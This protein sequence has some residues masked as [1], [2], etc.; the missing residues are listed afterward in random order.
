ME[1]HP[2][3]KDIGGTSAAAPFFAASTALVLQAAKEKNITLD[4]TYQTVYKLANSDAYNEVFQDVVIGN[5]DL[6]GVGCCTAGPAYDMASG[7]GSLNINS[8]TE[9]LVP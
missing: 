5:N 6:F 1:P 3:W 8:L 9:V 4:L 7:W 2:G